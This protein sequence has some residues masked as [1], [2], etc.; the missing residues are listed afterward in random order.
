MKGI[1]NATGMVSDAVQN[2][3]GMLFSGVKSQ[4]AAVSRPG[5]GSDH[6]CAIPS[7]TGSRVCTCFQAVGI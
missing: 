6:D 5:L 4:K 2:A 3:T 7:T 1:K